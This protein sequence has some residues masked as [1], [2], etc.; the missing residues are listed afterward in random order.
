MSSLPMPSAQ[1]LNAFV[2]GELG[3]ARQL[4]V[5]ALLN[6]DATLRAEVERLQ[7]LRAAV[8]GQAEYHVLPAALQARVQRMLPGATTPET[9]AAGPASP[10]APGLRAGAQRWF[11]W[12]PLLSG[13]A[14]ASLAFVV[15]EHRPRGTDERLLQEVTASHVRS[16]VG[17]RLVDVASS[18]RHTVKPW[19]SAHLDYSPPVGEVAMPALSFVGGRVDYLDGRP[20]AALVYRQRQ[21]VID[22][23]VWPS[24]ARDAGMQAS[25]QRGFNH[26]QWV[27]GGMRFWL[28]SDLNAAEL[29]AFAK[30]LDRA[31]GG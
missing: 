26:L 17:E 16:T 12:R 31:D 22:A 2:D 23:Y 7:A 9:D 4:E 25:A 8:R 27:R 21:H 15:V 30:A 24:T 14:L 20:V 11:A 3:L 10:A 6:A 18:D 19:L 5:E 13:L 28:V 1:E 29:A